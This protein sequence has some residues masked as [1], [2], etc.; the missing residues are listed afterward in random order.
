LRS[1]LFDLGAVR[2]EKVGDNGQW[3]LRL[4]LSRQDAEQLGRLPGADGVLVR[5][6]ILTPENASG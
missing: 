2:E 6:T 1:Q 3:L 5:E 4:E